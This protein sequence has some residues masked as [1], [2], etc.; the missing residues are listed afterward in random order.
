MA[1]RGRAYW[2]GS[3]RLS[4]VSIAVEVH[5]AVDTS[6]EI[7]F[8]QIHRPTGK[9]VNHIKSVQGVGPIESSEIVRGYEVEKDQYV[10]LEPSEID[11]ISAST[12]SG[13]S[14]ENPGVVVLLP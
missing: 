5:N 11:A 6:K 1:V 10:I 14:F 2:K 8:N 7:H 9:R 13:V 12:R 3:L 4:L